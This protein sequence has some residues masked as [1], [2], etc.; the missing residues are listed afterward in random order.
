VNPN[1]E[2]QSLSTFKRKA[3]DLIKRIK[4]TGRP[5]VLTVHG[6]AELVVQDAESYQ[7]LVAILDRLETIEGIRKG[8]EDMKAGRGQPA[9]EVFEEIRQKYKIPRHP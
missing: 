9:A 1:Q 7:Q 2:M 4:K 8:L 6:K 5:M 3:T